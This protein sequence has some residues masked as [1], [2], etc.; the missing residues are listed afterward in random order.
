[1]YLWKVNSLVEDFK[2][3]NVSQKEEFKYM[4][5]YTITM[6]LGTDPALYIGSSYN[7]YDTLT[8]VLMLGISIFGIFYC[9]KLNSSG[10]NKDF[11]VRLMCLGL[12][13]TI[14]VLTLMVPIFIIAGILE[15]VVLS[16]ET[17]TEESF[18]NTPIQ[19]TIISLFTASYF[20]YL[21]IKIKAVSS[22][23]T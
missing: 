3:G 9:Y 5:L 20:W 2:S 4:L 16:P 14:R 10:D 6:V 1:M 22:Q 23:N 7:Y 15:A 13:V 21:S 8:S 18:E 19:V 17:L 12:P 11:I